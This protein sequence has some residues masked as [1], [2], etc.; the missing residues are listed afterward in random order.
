[1]RFTRDAN[2]GMSV[3]KIAV[4]LGLNVMAGIGVVALNGCASGE[5]A[6]SAPTV[7]RTRAWDSSSRRRGRASYSPPVREENARS[8]RGGCS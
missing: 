3:W 5:P 7:C 8:E 6:T 1:M 4:N 2:K